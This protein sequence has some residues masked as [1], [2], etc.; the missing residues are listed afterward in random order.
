M[1]DFYANIAKTHPNG[2]R[3]ENKTIKFL[4]EYTIEFQNGN[5][6]NQPKLEMAYTQSK[7]RQ[8]KIGA[9]GK[10]LDLMGQIL[11]MHDTKNA[12]HNKL[13]LRYG[14]LVGRVYQGDPTVANEL[15][16]LLDALRETE[17]LGGV[18]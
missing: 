18:D 5:Y 7:A 1:R 15:Q 12:G 13:M 10:C 11:K 17:I 2:L 8:A 16:V 4:A 14:L 3:S 6:S 9:E